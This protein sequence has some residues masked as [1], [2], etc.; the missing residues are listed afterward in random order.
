MTPVRSERVRTCRGVSRSA[1]AVYPR[2]FEQTD[3]EL[4]ARVGTIQIDCRRLILG[5]LGLLGGIEWVDADGS[6]RTGSFSA[7]GSRGA[8]GVGLVSR[9][10]FPV[11]RESGG[12][13]WVGFDGA[14]CHAQVR[15]DPRE[16][17]GPR[18]G[19]EGEDSCTS[20]GRCRPEVA[21]FLSTP[22]PNSV[23]CQPRM[24]TACLDHRPFVV[25]KSARPG[26]PPTGEHDERR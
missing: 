20:I 16:E 1:L 4:S 26:L 13:C 24:V 18:C 12:A 22:A 9:D 10:W 17:I 14:G 23:P 25:R 21:S 8:R 3:D 6:E 15:D 5:G 7:N 19:T 2:T 11:V